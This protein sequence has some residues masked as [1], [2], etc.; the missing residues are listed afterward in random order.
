MPDEVSLKQL[1]KYDL[2]L[3]EDESVSRD[4][5]DNIFALEN[6]V[7]TPVMESISNQA[8]ISAAVQNLSVTI[9]PENML[10]RQLENGALRKI[11]VTDYEFTRNS[12]LVYHKDKFFGSA[13]KEIFDFCYKNYKHMQN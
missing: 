8:L 4:F 2:L 5:L 12:Y 6:I 3:R 13:K 11:T 9:M 7:V 10:T 1:C